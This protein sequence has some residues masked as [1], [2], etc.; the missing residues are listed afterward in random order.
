MDAH[1][2][3]SKTVR[4]HLK[5]RR[6]RELANKVALLQLLQNIKT[7]C[8]IARDVSTTPRKRL[9]RDCTSVRAGNCSP[10][11]LLNDCTAY[12]QC[13]LTLL[14]TMPP[15]ETAI[16]LDKQE[17]SSRARTMG[18]P[19]CAEWLVGRSADAT[20]RGERKDWGTQGQKRRRGDR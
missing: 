1:L 8:R 12:L 11:S 6:L 14:R 13:K 3:P 4:P 17:G 5:R 7:C 19:D 20:A 15:Q 10:V 2:R 9:V 18:A 16:C